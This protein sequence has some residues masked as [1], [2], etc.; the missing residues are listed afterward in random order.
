MQVKIGQ[1]DVTQYVQ[2]KSYNID[3]VDDYIEWKDANR[4]THRGGYSPKVMGSFE[5]VFIDGY[6]VSSGGQSS[7]VDHYGD[8]LTLLANN[9]TDKVLT[10]SLTVNNLN[11]VLKTIQCYCD[12]TTKSV[13]Y[14][15]NGSNCIV[16]R[17]T[18]NIKER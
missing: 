13:R 5:M 6:T 11:N 17:M 2:E 15:K 9:M 8:F 1:T 4:R 16:K 3:S 12:I 7:V 14:T 10:I 18:I